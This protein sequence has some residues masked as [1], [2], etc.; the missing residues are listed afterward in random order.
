M[1]INQLNINGFVM[2]VARIPILKYAI[3]EV[4]FP[5]ISLPEVGQPTPFQAINQVGD[6]IIHEEFSFTFLVDEKMN[7]YKAIY[8]WMR[9]LAFP[10]RFEEFENFVRNIKGDDNIQTLTTSSRLNQF[11]DVLITVLS[12]HKNPL[13]KYR[14][15]DAF[16][17][18][19]S[20]FSAN[21]TDAD[22]Q[23]I[24]ATCAMK[25]TGFEIEPA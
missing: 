9:G 17:V 24:T 6:H 10:E 14:L 13:F 25:F 3:Q 20:G 4:T 11:S 8:H 12:N 5:D 1:E 7:N 2:E 23:P 18:S 15:L 19:L 16:P 21:V 22:T